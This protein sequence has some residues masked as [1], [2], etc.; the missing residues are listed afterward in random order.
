MYNACYKCYKSFVK[1]LF[2]FVKKSVDSVLPITNFTWF[3]MLM[4]INDKFYNKLFNEIL[5]NLL[6][7]FLKQ[8][9]MN[10]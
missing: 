6:V 4:V 10:N 1:T 3:L 8:E 9:M 7:K 5:Q 2:I